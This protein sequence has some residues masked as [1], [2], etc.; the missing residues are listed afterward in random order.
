MR[1]SA[2]RLLL[3]RSRPSPLRRLC[4]LLRS[5]RIIKGVRYMRKWH[6][7]ITV[8]FGVFM[9]WMAFTGVASHVTALWPEGQQAGPPPVPQG[10]V[11][12]ETMMCRPKAA[13]GGMKSLVGWFHHLHSGEE[14]GPV[15]TAISL[16]T[17]LALLFFSISGLWMYYTMWKNRKDRGIKPGMFWK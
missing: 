11:C 17:G 8:F 15:G 5:I 9:V 1:Q 6:R 12:P 16:M 2:T 10:F 13:P 14:F 4:L 7:W 3:A